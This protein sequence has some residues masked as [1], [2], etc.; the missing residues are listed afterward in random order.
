MAVYYVDM[1]VGGD[2]NAGNAEG[3][4]NAWQTV[5]KAMN[6]VGAA[7]KVWVKASANY[8][9]LAT[10]DTVGTTTNPI[11]FEGYTATPGDGG[12]ATITGSAAR[13]NCIATTLGDGV[14]VF[15]VFKNFRLT[16]STG[17]AFNA[18]LDHLTF[19]NCKFDTAG[20]AGVWTQLSL[21]EDCD[22]ES[23][24]GDGVIVF[25]GGAIFV[26][27]TF[28]SNVVSGIICEHSLIV[29]N[30]TFF[31]NGSHTMKVGKTDALCAI[32]NC[33][34]DGDSKD[35]ITGFRLN[36][37]GIVLA[38][39]NTVAYDCGTG[40]SNDGGN[41]GERV[42]SRNN[43]VNANTADYNNMETFTGEVVAAPNFVNEAAGANY[44][45]ATG[46]PLIGAG[47][48]VG[49][50]MDIGAIQ[51]AAGGGG[52]LLMPNKRAGKQ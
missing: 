47:F 44:T 13:A 9:E 25:A 4:G 33:T 40:M 30:C 31:S 2:G 16:N 32:I 38:V 46:S 28:Y 8:T 27:C 50:N 5:D 12:R 15:Y 17:V 34:I 6:T 21:F 7:D 22:F 37:V 24:G 49:S 45:P 41:M 20:A 48:D 1:A 29:L 18:K 10:I 19:K 3:A 43:C 23:N 42:V 11:V 39:V 14:D 36:N 52:G 51:V 26:G 35:S